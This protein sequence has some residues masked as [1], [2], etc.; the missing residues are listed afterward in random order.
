MWF[1]TSRELCIWC[2][3][4]YQQS[5]L[6]GLCRFCDFGQVWIWQYDAAWLKSTSPKSDFTL[7]CVTICMHGL[8]RAVHYTLSL[9]HFLF[10]T[11]VG[12]ILVQL[13]TF[14]VP[15][16]VH[17]QQLHY[18]KYIFSTP[19]GHFQFCP[20][21]TWCGTEVCAIRKRMSKLRLINWYTTSYSH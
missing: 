15:V 20:I 9:W 14:F 3:L 8:S 11:G 6:G 7:E 1:V 5:T 16:N 4:A 21:C 17:K 2:L 10:K 12:K 18:C 19:K 13:K